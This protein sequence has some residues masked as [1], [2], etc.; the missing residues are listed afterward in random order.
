MSV[1]ESVLINV[2]EMFIKRMDRLSDI[3][4]RME[5]YLIEDARHKS[6]NAIY[7][8]VIFGFP[9][10]EIQNFNFHKHGYVY[11][12]FQIRQGVN[13][14]YNKLLNILKGK[15]DS[16]C[17]DLQKFIKEKIPNY[18][19]LE[20]NDKCT[21]YKCNDYNIDTLYEYLPEYILNE[22]ITKK[23]CLNDF[24]SFNHTEFITIHYEN[25]N[26]LYIDELL[27][28]VFTELEKVGYTANDFVTVNI[29]GLDKYLHN[30]IK[31]YDMHT[32]SSNVEKQHELM[33]NYIDSLCLCEKRELSTSILE[34]LTAQNIT[35]PI[36]NDNGFLV[37]EYLKNNIS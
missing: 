25:K 16:M 21:D 18:D 33:K 26:E 1:Q 4:T 34:C 30:L 15:E 14:L 13:T 2:F 20:D 36:F 8:G 31:I 32:P 28:K 12:K 23:L 29:V 6:N 19:Y 24:V 3:I 35:L 17:A 11:M 10:L 27:K 7:S 37:L 5:T 9:K 22:Y